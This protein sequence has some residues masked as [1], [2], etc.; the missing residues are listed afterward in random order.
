ME[1]ASMGDTGGFLLSSLEKLHL[2]DMQELQVIWKGPQQIATLQN[3]THLEIVDCKR[4]G[5]IFTPI[6]SLCLPLLEEFK[7]EELSK[8][9]HVF[10]HKDETNTATEE[11]MKSSL[12][13]EKNNTQLSKTQ[14]DHFLNLDDV[15]L[16]NCGVEEVF[17][18]K[19][20]QFHIF[21]ESE[22]SP[23]A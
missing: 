22:T 3:L 11:D 16:N 15:K 13:D 21:Q 17:Q 20:L 6:S 1:L 7:V 23:S 8:L 19:G 4:L 14:G 5:H 12:H 10:G 18:L 2:K 9:E